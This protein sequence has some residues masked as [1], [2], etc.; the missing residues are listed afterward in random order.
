ML[1]SHH[2]L[3]KY[4]PYIRAIVYHLHTDVKH[5]VFEKDA[6]KGSLKL[7]KRYVDKYWTE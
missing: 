4:F 6:W 5:P 3:K 7:H 1:I 2:S